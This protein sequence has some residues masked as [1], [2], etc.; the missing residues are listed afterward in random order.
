MLRTFDAVLSTQPHSAA[1]LDVTVRPVGDRTIVVAVAGELDL[2][3]APTLKTELIKSLARGY[4]DVVLDLSRVAHMDSTGLAVL[5]GL[6]ERIK[7]DG[8]LAL[9]GTPETVLRVLELTGLTGQFE[10]VATV[11]EA[12]GPVGEPPI[13]DGSG[14]TADAEIVLGLLATALPFAESR[15]AEAE[16]WLRVLQAHGDTLRLLDE[17]GVRETATTT[18]GR[19]LVAGQEASNPD[20]RDPIERVIEHARGLAGQ[21]GANVIGTIELLAGVIEVYASDFDEVLAAHGTSRGAVLRK[22]TEEA[23]TG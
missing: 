6:R 13:H 22:L 20:G 15:R 7:D 11:E 4:R 9:A 19:R 18:P 1:R 23:S 5:I 3:T 12:A 21:R 2:A 14:L 17:L 8:R 10:L 16:R